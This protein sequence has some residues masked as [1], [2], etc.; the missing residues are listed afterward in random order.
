MNKQFGICRGFEY[1]STASEPLKS[2]AVVVTPENIQELYPNDGQP[3][4]S[5]KLGYA[6]SDPTIGKLI[7]NFFNSFRA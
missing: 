5:Y 2:S 7:S 1:P 4:D 6:A 3:T